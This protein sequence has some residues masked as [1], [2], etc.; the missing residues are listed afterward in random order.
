MCMVPHMFL[1][2]FS[3]EDFGAPRGIIDMEYYTNVVVE[4]NVVSLHA[5][6]S[7]GA[8]PLHFK[9]HDPDVRKQWIHS[10]KR[11][12]FQTVQDERDMYQQLQEQFSGQMNSTTKMIDDLSLIHI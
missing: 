5:D 10:M 12:R 8:R 9:I 3:E 2:Y 4:D 6:K 11:D 7:L 1:Y